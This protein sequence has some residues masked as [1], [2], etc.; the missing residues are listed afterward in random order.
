M[1]HRQDYSVKTAKSEP[2]LGTCW[3]GIKLLSLI[4]MGSKRHVVGWDEYILDH[5]D[6]N[7]QLIKKY[8]M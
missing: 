7:F 1:K 4:G 8:I 3:L 6:V 2:H 5:Y